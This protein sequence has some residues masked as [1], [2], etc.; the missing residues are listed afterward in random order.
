M[1]PWRETKEQQLAMIRSADPAIL[2][3]S[4]SD[5]L[6]NARAHVVE[7]RRYGPAAWSRFSHSRDEILWY[8]P[9]LV[10]AFRSNPASEPALVHELARAVA[11]LE[12]LA[13][14]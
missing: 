14:D 8:Y 4:G 10:E 11:E 13:A 2:L 7:L 3:V 1:P 12:R 6:H 5:K 9:S